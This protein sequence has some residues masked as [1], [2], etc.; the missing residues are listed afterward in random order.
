MIQ[1]DSSDMHG[2]TLQKCMGYL[3][4][5]NYA[6]IASGFTSKENAKPSPNLWSLLCLLPGSYGS[7]G[8]WTTEHWWDLTIGKRS[9]QRGIRGSSK[10][11]KEYQ[12]ELV[13]SCVLTTKLDSVQLDGFGMVWHGHRNSV[14][15]TAPGFQ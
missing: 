12:Q 11:V 14:N 2:Y 3:P 1:L 5:R 8:I 9:Q 6:A 7:K 10:D 15:Q 4:L 13:A